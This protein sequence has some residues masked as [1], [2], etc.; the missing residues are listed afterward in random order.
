MTVSSA[1]IIG[2]VLISVITKCCRIAVSFLICARVTGDITV[3]WWVV[4]IPFYVWYGNA[5]IGSAYLAS[6]RRA[7]SQDLPPDQQ[8]SPCSSFFSSMISMGLPLASVLMIAAK[9]E[10]NGMPLE[11]CFIPIFI[12]IGSGICLCCCLSVVVMA[13]SKTMADDVAAATE[14]AEEQQGQQQDATGNG[15]DDQ[16]YRSKAVDG[17][18]NG[19][20]SKPADALSG[21]PLNLRID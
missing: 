3:S 18:A 12:V 19:A 10:G 13:V 9:I 6:V 20:Q 16:P 14:Q 8:P 11:E 21:Q 17:Y 2:L 4:F 5:V 15:A 1:N 7:S